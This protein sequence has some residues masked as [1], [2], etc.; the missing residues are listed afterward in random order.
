MVTVIG[1]V[2]TFVGTTAWKFVLLT[3]AIK[4]A[5]VPLKFTLVV[6]SKFFPVMVTVV[7]GALLVGVKLVI[8]AG[9]KKTPEL[10]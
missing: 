10:V 6:P 7:P 9:K 3:G 2:V 8:R 1:P 5:G 4:L